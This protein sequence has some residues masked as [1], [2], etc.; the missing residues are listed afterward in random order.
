MCRGFPRLQ[1]NPGKSLPLTEPTFRVGIIDSIPINQDINN[2]LSD[3]GRCIK[4]N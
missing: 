4:E 3:R 1:S 2:L